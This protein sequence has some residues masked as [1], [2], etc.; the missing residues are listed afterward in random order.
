[1]GDETAEMTGSAQAV[2]QEGRNCWRIE[3]A[4]RVAVVIDAAD[5]YRTIRQAML[6]A[7]ERILLIGWDFDTRIALDRSDDAVPGET[8]G[9]FLLTLAK[10]RPEIAIDILKWDVGSL[11]MLLRGSTPLTLIRWAMTRQ[12]TFKLDGAHPPACSH[13]QKIVVID[14]SLAVCG[15][16]DMTADRW[17]TSEHADDDPRRVRPS[18]RPYGPWHDVTMVMDGPAA[19]ALGELSR[20]RWALAT[21]KTL[22]PIRDGGDVWPDGLEPHL[23][24]VDLAISRTRAK[25]KGNEEI[26]EVEALFIDMIMSAKRFIYAEN[27]YFASRKVAEAIGKRMAEDDPPEIVIIGPEKA[28]GWLEQKAM[29]GARV[30]L[31]Q[32]IG[33][34]DKGNRF[35]IYT[36]VTAAGV[37]IYVH[38]KVMIVDDVMLRIGSS[39]M[40]NRSLGLDSECDCTID[41][42]MAGNGEAGATIA[43]LRARLVSE[44]LGIEPDAFERR[45]ADSGSLIDTIESFRGDGRTLK[46]LEFEKPDA[47]EEFIADNEILDPE[48]ADGFFEPLSKRGLFRKWRERVHWPRRWRRRVPG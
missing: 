18:G 31:G 17:D 33:A 3:H 32:A 47:V 4:D 28:D 34:L 46:L 35:R 26:R 7:R 14:D 36:P 37:P 24:N 41:T 27:Q 40:N 13:H 44:H 22:P 23:T 12:I 19:R 1:M 11:K 42:R 39:N 38:A 29:D 21:G 2:P 25:F 20:D 10:R 6:N 43:A 9:S 8:L 15:G 5:Y 45:F 16:I 30:K 48:K